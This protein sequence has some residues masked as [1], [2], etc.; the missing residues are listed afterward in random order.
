MNN[1]CMT[2]HTHAWSYCH[3]PRACFSHLY[4]LL[5]SLGPNSIIPSYLWGH[6][7]KVRR[8][9]HNCYPFINPSFFRNLPEQ[10]PMSDV[11]MAAKLYDFV[12]VGGGTAGLVVASR[13]SEDPSQ[14]ILVL[15]AGSD[16]AEDPRVNTPGMFPVML[17]SEIDWGFHTT[18]QVCSCSV[19]WWASRN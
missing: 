9:P 8:G 1:T 7:L 19:T 10:S 17:G 14:R 13:L 11:N 6:R 12:I 4:V 15:E 5:N 16:L 3:M 18:P 2:L